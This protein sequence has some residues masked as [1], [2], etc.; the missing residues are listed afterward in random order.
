MAF[1]PYLSVSQPMGAPK[2]IAVIYVT[3][4]IQ[5]MSVLVYGSG[6][7]LSGDC[8][9]EII[10]DSHPCTI[11]KLSNG[12]VTADKNIFALICYLTRHIFF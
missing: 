7:G 8:S 3:E 9:T 4:A 11:P 10:G 1:L 12:I 5:D 2:I 6:A